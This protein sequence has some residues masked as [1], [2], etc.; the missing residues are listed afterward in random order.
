MRDENGLVVPT[1]L[2]LVGMVIGA[3]AGLAVAQLNPG[4]SMAAVVEKPPFAVGKALDA[5]LA[6][7]DG[8]YYAIGTRP[9]ITLEGTEVVV[10]KIGYG[11]P[12]FVTITNTPSGAYSSD[13]LVSPHIRYPGVYTQRLHVA[14]SPFGGAVLGWSPLTGWMKIPLESANSIGFLDTAVVPLSQHGVCVADTAAG[15]CR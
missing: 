5:H 12:R 4:P 9:G 3:V 8:D 2:A 7:F 14:I 10:E 11:K 13:G 1:K 6:K 15:D